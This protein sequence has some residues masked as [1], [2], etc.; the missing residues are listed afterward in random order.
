M[1][2]SW[3]VKVDRGWWGFLY[4]V[5]FFTV[6]SVLVYIMRMDN[7]ILNLIVC[8]VWCLVTAARRGRCVRWEIFWF[9]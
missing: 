9:G 4:M 7:A 3:S 6:Y 5:G 1:Y 2:G 8:V